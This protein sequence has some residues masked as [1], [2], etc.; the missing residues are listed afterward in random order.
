MQ[1]VR[2][3]RRGDVAVLTIANPP[4]NAIGTAVVAGLASAIDRFEADRSYKAL[5]VHCDGSTFVAGG[6]IGSFDDPGFSAA[7]FNATLDRIETL[8]R[9]VVASLHGSVLGGGLELALACHWRVALP[10]TKLGM[11]E[12]KLGL[13]PGS[14]GTQ[15]LP[16]VAGI[17][18]ALD[19]IS[20]GRNISA[21]AAK[22]AGIIDEVSDGVPLETGLAFAQA[23]I[24][25]GG[26]ARRISTLIIPPGG[27][28]ADFFATAAN[29]ARTK[30]SFYPAAAAIVQAVQASTLPFK[31]G[32][33][34]EARLFEELRQSRESMALRHLFF[35]ECEAAKVPGLA[36]DV[37]TRPITKVGIVGAGTMGGGIAM[38]F[39]NAGIQTVLVETSQAALERGLGMMKGNYEASAA[40]GRLTTQQV[41]QRMA[42][43]TGSLDYAA[44]SDCDLVIEAV[45]ENMELK[46]QICARLG[47]VCKSGAIIAT[48]TSTL[49]VDV[50]AQATARAQDVVGMHFFSPANVMRLLEV[51][52]GAQTAPDVLATVMQLA[53]K[54]GKVAVVSGVCY[55][56]IGNRMAEV[57]MREAEFLLMEGATPS[58]IDGAVE[59]LGM[60]MGPCRMLD[61][62][63]ID[64]GAKTVIEYGKAGGL[65]PDPTYRAV[66]RRMFELG[67]FG[68]KTGAGYYRYE[69]RK[70]EEDPETARIAKELAGTHGIAQRSEISRQEIIERLL[71]PLINE[72][73]KIFEEGIA[74]R[75]GDI[76]VVWTAGYGFPDHKGG[77]MFYADSLGLGVIADRMAHYAATRG[78]AYGYW[79]LSPLL[80][81]Q[82]G[83]RKQLIDSKAGTS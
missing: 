81:K 68:Q 64:V 25:R 56:F 24:S 70:P 79:T 55:G 47:Q 15:R 74:W 11:P 46:K 3:E 77:P 69:G 44:L 37:K 72:G 40:K 17:K 50:L 28:E 38:N 19:M 48:N 22:D 78:N 45:F 21:Q 30:K 16:R 31:D 29:D 58:Q 4:V 75:P 12:V 14:L 82:A 62:A 34:V 13:L 57:Y 41:S 23:L 18:L 5:L 20:T 52:R 1:L 43:L 7:P 32:A 6:D 65:P 73:F 9:P 54:I 26:A 71:Y 51:V 35:A 8:D 63:G 59:S 36:K 39:A 49:D 80:Q 60:A 10:S 83:E 61:M 42:L 76:D 53:R 2:L 27:I 33:A 67:R 66:V